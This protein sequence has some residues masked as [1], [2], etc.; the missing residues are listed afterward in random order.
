MTD[1]VKFFDDQSDR[2]RRLTDAPIDGGSIGVVEKWAS[3]PLAYV[4]AETQSNS[5]TPFG[6]VPQS[7][8]LKLLPLDE[9]EYKKFRTRCDGIL[10]EVRELEASLARNSFADNWVG[11]AAE[12]EMLLEDLYDTRWGKS[13]SLKRVV[14]KLQAQLNNARWDHR[15]VAFLKEVLRGLR[16][17]YSIDET[18][19]REVAEAVTRHGLDPFRG[20]LSASETLKRLKIVEEVVE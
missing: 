3:R 15:H 20:S 11:P 10:T 17:R 9:R 4:T 14:V 16:V 8:A 7:K 13:E 5:G 2:H 18:A 12:I 19:V 6:S 1:Q